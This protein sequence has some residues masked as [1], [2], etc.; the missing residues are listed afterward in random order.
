MHNVLAGTKYKF[1]QQNLYGILSVIPLPFDLSLF[2]LRISSLPNLTLNPS[3]FFVWMIHEGKCDWQC[4]CYWKKI[5]GLC[6]GPAA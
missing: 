1:V 5:Q 3:S 4:F 2:E 6:C